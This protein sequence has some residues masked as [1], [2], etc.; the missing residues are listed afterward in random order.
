MSSDPSITIE[1]VL[2]EQRVF[3]PSEQDASKSKIGSMSA[4]KHIAD[5]AKDDPE[6]FWGEAAKRELHWFEPFHSP[7]ACLRRRRKFYV[8][9]LY[10]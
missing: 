2:Q 5:L 3:M 7:I 1:S 9:P 10:F 8:A 4:Y 6:T